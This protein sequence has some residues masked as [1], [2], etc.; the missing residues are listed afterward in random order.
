M[1]TPTFFS[2]LLGKEK[3]ILIP[4][5]QSHMIEVRNLSKIYNNH[6]H[7][8]K[9]V[10]FSIHDGE[11]VGFLGPNGAGKTTT[12]KIITGYT[13]PTQ[14]T[15]AVN[16]CDVLKQ[17]LEVKRQIGYL[18]E[19]VPLYDDMRVLEYLEFIGAIRLRASRDH[20][21]SLREAL[22]RVVSIC[23]L[24]KMLRRP[25]GELSK[26]FRQRTCLAQ[27][28][29]H[30]PDILILDEPTSGLDPNQIAEIR[31]VIR[32][33]GR[34]KTVILSTHILQEVHALCTRVIIIN[35]GKIVAHGTTA[36][37]EQQSQGKQSVFV[38]MRGLKER[39]HELLL[40]LPQAEMVHHRE[41]EGVDIFG[42]EIVVK[43]SED[44]R[45]ALFH[46]AVS[47][48]TPILEMRHERMSLEDVFRELTK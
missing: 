18:P 45:E 39:I 17:P 14:G 13:A 32:A 8:L 15:V 2:K 28:L 29:I 24:Q 4:G 30:N 26:G 23:G 31:D 16:G 3:A 21:L 48:Q 12:M 22:M 41:T 40:D 47:A 5:D 34:E 36:E 44:I 19:S 9:D 6:I 43:G 10:N 20:S 11:I 37:L 1:T 25:I 35:E 46:R 33:I 42:F 38:K 7:A 27:A